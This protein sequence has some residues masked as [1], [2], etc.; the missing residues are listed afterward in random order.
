MSP[1]RGVPTDYRFPLAEPAL[2]DLEEK[3]V[4]DA[5]RSGWVSSRGAYLDRFEHEF[6]AWCRTRYAVATANGTVALHLALAAAGIG[7]GDEVIVPALTYVATAN[8]VVYCGARPVFVDVCPRTWC[9]DPGQVRAA[10]T[11]R[12]RAVL[13][14]DLYGQ[15][16]DYP[17]LRRLCHEHGLLLVADAAESLGASV[18][19][20]PVGALADLTTFSFF[21]NKILTC[22]EGGAVVTTD[23]LLVERMRMLRNQGMDPQRRYYHPLIGF[24]YRLTN[25]AAAMLCAQLERAEDLLARRRRIIRGYTRALAGAAGLAERP[26]PDPGTRRAPWMAC[27][28]VAGG[29]RAV[30][31]TLLR[32]LAHLGVETRPFFVPLPELPPYRGSAGRFP[33]STDLAARGFNLPT[34]PRLTDGDV[35]EIAARVRA[36]AAGLL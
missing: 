3:Y 15:P 23:P 5:V 31:D 29:G 34:L 4:L 8:A 10:V 12:T 20:A 27:A 19:G 22:G 18:A 9:L 24:N 28:L 30:R 32:R 2:S 6:A 16:A 35:T 13:A 21:G 36:V 26:P 14:V 25:V 7:P 17:A 33:V 1:R 11:N